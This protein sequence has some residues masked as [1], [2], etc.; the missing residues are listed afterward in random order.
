MIFVNEAD[1][2]DQHARFITA[3]DN[4]YNFVG[5]KNYKANL[6]KARDRVTR[7]EIDKDH[8]NRKHGL[9]IDLIK[10]DD[11][12][13]RGR[14]FNMVHPGD[15][16]GIGNEFFDL[17]MRYVDA[18]PNEAKKK[19]KTDITGNLRDEGLFRLH[20]ELQVFNT[21]QRFGYKIELN[22]II[23]KPGDP[24][25]DFL[26]HFGNQSYEVEAKCFSTDTGNP[27]TTEN[28]TKIRVE[29][30]KSKLLSMLEKIGN[31]GSRTIVLR[32]SMDATFSFSN[33]DNKSFINSCIDAVSSKE[34]IV[35]KHYR[36]LYSE[37]NY[38]TK[39][40]LTVRNAK[41]AASSDTHCMALA[42]DKL[43]S[44]NLLL[45]IT[46]TRDR[47]GREQP[48]RYIKEYSDKQFS[49]TRPAVI[50]CKLHMLRESALEI[51]SKPAP[52]GSG[53]LAEWC[54][55]VVKGGRRNQ[56]KHV[57]FTGHEQ[58]IIGPGIN[59]IFRKNF[60]QSPITCKFTVPNL[61]NNLESF[62]A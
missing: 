12:R 52:S 49:G 23:A 50:F 62:A 25:F 15:C 3:R 55:E 24:K 10:L 21:L 46:S 4:F 45:E 42:A 7:N 37:E 58:P 44:H 51:M 16:T 26:V 34:N 20:Y 57:V 11:Y 48:I 13:Q 60:V 8:Q 40:E 2:R 39:L 28:D 56:L 17:V 38:A 47:R 33:P 61:F 31:E 29:F 14:P 18:M 36:I 5:E 1:E 32:A 30:V 59:K 6:A 35:A 53:S 41:T 54:A 9:E 43:S 27:I 19:L 22:E